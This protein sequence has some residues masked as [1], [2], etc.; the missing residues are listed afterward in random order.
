MQI[1]KN[2]IKEFFF[3]QQMC[4]SHLVFYAVIYD[5][6]CVCDV[7]HEILKTYKIFII[8]CVCVRRCRCRR[9]LMAPPYNDAIQRK[10]LVEM[11]GFWPTNLCVTLSSVET[12][13]GNVVYDA[14][15]NMICEKMRLIAISVTFPM[16]HLCISWVC[17]RKMFYF[18]FFIYMSVCRGICL[19]FNAGWMADS[20]SINVSFLCATIHG[21]PICSFFLGETKRKT[22]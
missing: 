19:E 15:N 12:F 17:V 9:E 13:V 1:R 4:L 2:T 7:D 11:I 18:M 5:L 20:N 10:M 22:M 14:N 16:Q 8:K 6:S 21:G 3:C